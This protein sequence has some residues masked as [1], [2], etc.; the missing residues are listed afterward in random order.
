MFQDEALRQLI[1]TALANNFDL[2]IAGARDSAGG[3]A[4]RHHAA[5][6]SCP[7][8]TGQVSGQGQRGA[9]FG[10]E[11]A[12]DRHRAG[13][14]RRCRGSSTSGASTGGPL[15]RRAP[16]SRA[17]EWGRRAIVT[18]LVSEV[19]SQYFDAARAR[20]RARD[21]AR[22]RSPSREE[23]L[24]LTEVRERG[25]ATSLVD[26]RQAEQLVLRRAAQIVDVQRPHRAAGERAERRCSGAQSRPD[27]PR[28]G[29]GRAAARRRTCRP[30]LP[31]ALLERRPDMQQ[32]EQ[33]LV[34]ANAGSASP[35][36]S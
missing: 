1:T 36:R 33:R 31:S 25:G 9:I 12:D 18:S 16:I 4:A 27:R 20:P 32:A 22:A 35:R 10:G 30:G 17:R 6:I 34:A 13:Q 5:P 24:R 28:P 23:S 21:R 8:V 11:R 15:K 14:R 2:R 26:V 29:A 7:T 19:A 3:G